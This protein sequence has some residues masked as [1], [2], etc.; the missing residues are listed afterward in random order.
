MGRLMENQISDNLTEIVLKCGPV[1]VSL[2]SELVGRPWWLVVMAAK[3]SLN[4]TVV[5]GEGGQDVIAFDE[6]VFDPDYG[7]VYRKEADYLRKIGELP[8]RE[9]RQRARA[10]RLANEMKKASSMR[11]KGE[12]IM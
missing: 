5:K 3:N 6:K 11:Q 1:P 9:I 12:W 7:I 10:V 8:L 4:L 2:A